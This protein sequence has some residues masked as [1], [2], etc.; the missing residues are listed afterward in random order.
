MEFCRA[1]FICLN[2]AHLSVY[3]SPVPPVAEAVWLCAGRLL[4]CDQHVGLALDGLRARDLD[5]DS[6]SN[7]DTIATAHLLLLLKSVLILGL[8]GALPPP[9]LVLPARYSVTSLS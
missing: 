3:L 6:V 9:L 8:D 5:R 1:F 7:T 4:G 2:V